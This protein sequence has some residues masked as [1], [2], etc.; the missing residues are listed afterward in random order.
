[1]LLTIMSNVGMFGGNVPAPPTTIPPTPIA[2]E[3]GGYTKRYDK[4]KENRKILEEDDWLIP[5]I[6]EKILKECQ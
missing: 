2:V 4:E 5:L 3:G 1:M 6:I